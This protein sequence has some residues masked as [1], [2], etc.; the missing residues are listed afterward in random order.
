MRIIDDFSNNGNITPN[1]GCIC[2]GQLD[3][4]ADTKGWWDPI[5]RCKASCIGKENRD[6]NKNCAKEETRTAY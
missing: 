3:N 2:N 1:A 6:G 4:Q 5:I